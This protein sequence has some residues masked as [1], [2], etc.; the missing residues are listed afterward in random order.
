[1]PAQ[2][3]PL[4]KLFNKYVTFITPAPNMIGIDKRKENLTALGLSKERKR[5]AVIVIPDL[6]TP[7]I[8][9]RALTSYVC[10]NTFSHLT[11]SRPED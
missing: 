4:F 1:M 7:G 11:S 10:V 5:A 8:I 2:K 9:A 3:R 6:D